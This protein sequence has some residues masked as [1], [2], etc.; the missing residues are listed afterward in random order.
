M[1]SALKS[2][3]AV[4]VVATAALGVVA[5]AA[6]AATLPELVNNKGVELAKN[7]FTIKGTSNGSY[8]LLE[9][10]K[11]H[12]VRCS[13]LSG[14]GEVKG[15]K[16][17]EATF[18]YTTCLGAGGKCTTAGAKEGEIKVTTSIAPVW[19]SKTAEE[20]ALLISVKPVTNGGIQ[21]TCDG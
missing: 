3:L 9:T 17:G 1:R 21:F 2:M 8:V 15:T 12:T 5:A 7:K 20:V 4:L 14:N 6:T 19:L 13:G 18:T 11:R 10:T 16:G